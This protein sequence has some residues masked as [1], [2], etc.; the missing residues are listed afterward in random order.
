MPPGIRYEGRILSSHHSLARPI[1]VP[2][3]GEPRQ[4]A[5]RS[6]TLVVDTLRQTLLKLSAGDLTVPLADEFRADCKKLQDDCNATMARL[7]HPPQPVRVVPRCVKAA[8]AFMQANLHKPL[9]MIDIAKA[10]GASVR[11][12]QAGFR[13]AENTTPQAYL[14]R[15]RLDAVHAELSSS[16]NRL[17]VSE[18][19]LKWGFT[20]MGRFAAQYRAA[21][22]LSPSERVKRVQERRAG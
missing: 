22:G 8:I 4:A 9:T 12:L 16:E 7:Q 6:L 20:H 18:V 21:Y 15:I 19:A 13:L 10:S 11:S 1:A 17:P 14:R 5:I 3:S 2:D